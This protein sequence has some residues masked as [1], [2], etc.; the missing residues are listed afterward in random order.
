LIEP[1]RQAALDRLQP[2]AQRT[3]QGAQLLAGL[4]GE[5]VAA[6]GV[7]ADLLDQGG[8]HQEQVQKDGP[9]RIG[10]RGGRGATFRPEA[11]QQLGVELVGFL[12]LAEAAGEGA[13]VGGI[14]HRK[15]PARLGAGLAQRVVETPG[16]LADQVRAL[17]QGSHVIGEDRGRVD[18]GGGREAAEGDRVLGD[19]GADVEGCLGDHAQ[20]CF[21]R[22]RALGRPGPSNGSG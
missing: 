12:Q 18:D 13:R 21:W 1:V 17:R 3:A 16:G 8:A 4:A 6:A 20:P 9:A 5:Q 22:T 19:I 15:R 7:G 10:W 2:Q 14:D 11:P